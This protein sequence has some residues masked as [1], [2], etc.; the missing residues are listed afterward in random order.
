MS[1][2]SAALAVPG[3]TF[4]AQETEDV[5]AREAHRVDAAL[6]ADGT[7]RGGGVCST[8]VSYLLEKLGGSRGIH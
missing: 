8:S 7:L 6:Q 5:A 2:E 1:A 3:G 4:H